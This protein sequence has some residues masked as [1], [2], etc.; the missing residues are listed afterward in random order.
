[1][2]DMPKN[3]S[4]MILPLPSEATPLP[5]GYKPAWM[6]FNINQHIRVK[7]HP[8]GLAELHRQDDVF[9]SSIPLAAA[10][11]RRPA[12]EMY[13]P[14]ADGYV[15]FQA[16]DLMNRFGHMMVMGCEP[17][18]ETAVLVERAAT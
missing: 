18:F 7:L 10:A 1:M 3:N 9:Y 14:D 15:D 5:T 17:P 8:N 2:Y 13:R 11:H 16:W 4:P 12:S 6:P